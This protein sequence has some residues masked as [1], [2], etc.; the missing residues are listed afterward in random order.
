MFYV[1]LVYFKSNG[2][3]YSSASY[4]SERGHLFEIWE[5]V[6]EFQKEG[7]LPGLVD[8]AR[9]PLI[10]VKVPMHPHSHPHLVVDPEMRQT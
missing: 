3:F 2:K 1:K 5:E 6:S 10:H 7:K 8:G 9:M 4:V